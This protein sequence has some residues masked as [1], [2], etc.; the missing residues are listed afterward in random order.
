MSGV[1]L[2]LFFFLCIGF[3]AAFPVLPS[4]EE[5]DNKVDSTPVVQAT[6]R[7]AEALPG[8]QGNELFAFEQ[9]KRSMAPAPSRVRE[10][11]DPQTTIFN[12]VQWEDPRSTS[13]KFSAH[14]QWE[15]VGEENRIPI[16]NGANEMQQFSKDEVD[17]SAHQIWERREEPI[18]L[19]AKHKDI[20]TGPV[21]FAKVQWD[22][23]GH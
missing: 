14:M 22:E 9:W 23:R 5:A 10:G 19:D 3:A 13:L 17:F 1:K 21:F 2:N 16:R 15:E 8:G 11:R 7:T 12:H 20:S 6:S 18:G 4:I